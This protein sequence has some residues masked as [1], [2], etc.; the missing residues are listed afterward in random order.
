MCCAE[1]R[2]PGDAPVPCFVNFLVPLSSK[3]MVLKCC[4]NNDL[5]KAL[6]RGYDSVVDVPE[7]IDKNVE[8]W[9]SCGSCGGDPTLDLMFNPMLN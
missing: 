3:T 5:P 4:L 2:G 7:Q 1:P 8:V 9:V 6:P